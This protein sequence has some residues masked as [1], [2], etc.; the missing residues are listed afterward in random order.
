M[1]TIDSL[2]DISGT[3]AWAQLPPPLKNS[4][5]GVIFP[6]LPDFFLGKG[7]GQLYIGYRDH[8]E[9]NAPYY[10]SLFSF[11][12]TCTSTFK[13]ILL[14]C[15]HFTVSGLANTRALLVLLSGVFTL[16]FLGKGLGTSG[17]F[18]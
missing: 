13:I 16:S 4:E 8:N 5:K 7:G 9:K 17:L 10:A 2:T 12:N 18:R 6:S 1:F 3:I 11:Y 14:R 15:D